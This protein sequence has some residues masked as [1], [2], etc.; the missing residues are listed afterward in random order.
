MTNQTY[1]MISMKLP[2][3]F[4][5]VDIFWRR[6]ENEYSVDVDDFVYDIIS[7]FDFEFS[8]DDHDEKDEM[9]EEMLELLLF[10]E[11]NSETEMDQR[12]ANNLGRNFAFEDLL[13]VADES[14]A[15]LNQKST[16]TPMLTPKQIKSVQAKLQCALQ[17]SVRAELKYMLEE[18]VVPGLPD[19]VWIDDFLVNVK[20][21]VASAEN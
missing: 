9:R 11:Y 19:D 7:G 1:E 10:G 20:V 8:E 14:L 4:T 15:E 2:N 3:A 6:L 18:S 17:E 21:T 13:L 12:K 5:L 16:I